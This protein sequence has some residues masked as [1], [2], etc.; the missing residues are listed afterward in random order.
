MIVIGGDTLID[1]IDHGQRLFEAFPG[2]STLNCALAAGQL[3]SKVLYVSTLSSD[4]Y[5]DLLANRLAQCNVK[6]R[7]IHV[8]RPIPLAVVSLDEM[9]QPSMLFIVMD[10]RPGR[11]CC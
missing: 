3:G 9:N 5:G 7:A 11:P 1:L 8:P 6:L 10:G 4:S 2:G